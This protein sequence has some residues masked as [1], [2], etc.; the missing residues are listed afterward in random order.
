MS[1]QPNI[2]IL[3]ERKK[4]NK[5]NEHK[6]AFGSRRSNNHAFPCTWNTHRIA[7]NFTC[8]DPYHE[9]EISHQILRLTDPNSYTKTRP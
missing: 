9:G 2:N 5:I 8:S 3:K 7:L 4:S 6:D 1:D